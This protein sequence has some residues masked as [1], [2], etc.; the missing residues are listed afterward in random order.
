MKSFLIFLAGCFL[1]GCAGGVRS[2]PPAEVYDFGPPVEPLTRDGAWSSVAIEIR[3]PSWFDS[4]DIEYR[5]L[6]E[7]PRKLRGYAGSHWVASPGLLL[8]QRLRQQIGLVGAT[9]QTA[10]RCLLRLELFEFSQVFDAPQRSRGLLQG[11]VSILAASRQAVADRLVASE[12]PAPSADA[13]GAV[14]ALVAASDELGQQL[15]AWL[16]DL[17]KRGRLKPCQE[18]TAENR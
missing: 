8:S 10:A 13:R 2:G 5:L 7:N 14:I 12:Q 16:N 4:R 18:P 9:G 3:A 1:A 17:E 11:R 15:A 6:Y